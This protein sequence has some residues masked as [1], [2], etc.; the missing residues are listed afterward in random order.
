[1]PVAR[2][3]VPGRTQGMREN[4]ELARRHDFVT[5]QIKRAQNVG[6]RI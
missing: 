6:Q 1:M 3:R 5:Q 2:M 4:I